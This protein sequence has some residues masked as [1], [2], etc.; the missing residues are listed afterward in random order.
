MCIVGVA[1]FRDYS[2]AALKVRGRKLANRVRTIKDSI[3]TWHRGSSA[4]F[5]GLAQI[6]IVPR[7]RPNEREIR[8]APDRV[9]SELGYYTIN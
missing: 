3:C 8:I 2:Q 1:N 5:R 9:S 4:E 6:G 7:N